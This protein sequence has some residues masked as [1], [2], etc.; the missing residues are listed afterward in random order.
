MFVSLVDVIEHLNDHVLEK[1]VE[2]VFGYLRPKYCF[3]STPNAEFNKH[4]MFVE[5]QRRHPDHLF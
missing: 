4:F 2:N 1:V 3:I 5:G